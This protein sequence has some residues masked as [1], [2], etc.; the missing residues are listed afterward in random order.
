[1]PSQPDKATSLQPAGPAR[2]V[3]SRGPPSDFAV[4]GLGASAGGLDACRKFVEALPPK[5]GMAIIL[6]QHLDPTHQSMMVDLLAQHTT[7]PVEQAVEGMAVEPGHI[8]VIPPGNY[9]SVKSG[10]LHLMEPSA[11]HGARL[12]FNFLLHSLAEEYGPRAI[13]VVLSGTGADGSLGLASIHKAGGLVIVQDP[14][15]ALY[16]GMPR[17]AISTG[18][19][20]FVLPAKM[21]PDALL[22]FKRRTVTAH[23]STLSAAQDVIHARLTEI[24]A[25]LR[26]NTN[27]NFTHYKS[28]TLVRRIERRIALAGIDHADINRYFDLLRS[29]KNEQELLAKD[30]LINVTSFFR[31]PKVFEYLSAVTIPDLIRQHAPHTTLRVW[32]AGCSTGEEVYSLAIVFREVIAAASR[33]IKL[34]IFASDIDSDAVAIAREGFY[35]SSI[36]AVVSPE[37]LTRFFEKEDLG[38]R[39]TPEL[40]NMIIFA[41]QDILSD[42]PFSRLDMISCRNLLIYLRPE[43]QEKA[44]SA[45][46]FALRGD[47]VLLLGDSETVGSTSKRF[48]LISKVGQLYRPVGRASPRDVDFSAGSGVRVSARAPQE[49][50]APRQIALAALCQKMVIEA[51]APAVV[52][53]N[54]KYECL[55]CLGPTDKY[56]KIPPGHPIQDLLAMARDGIRAKLRTVIQQAIGENARVV[57]KGGRINL[58]DAVHRFSIAAQPLATDGE[59]LLMISFLDDPQP[60]AAESQPAEPED[61]SQVTVLEQELELTRAELQSAIR[62][63]EISSEAQKAVNEEALSVNEEFQSTNEELLTSKEELQ[64]LNEELTVLNSQLQETLARQRATSDDLRNVLYS[65]DIATIFLDTNLNIRFYTPAT[66]SLFSIIPSDVG[67]P[68]A[69]LNS[70]AGGAALLADAG[71]VLRTGSPIECEIETESRAV[72]IRRILPYRTEDNSI[73]GVVITFSDITERR[74]TAD[75]LEAAKRQ[76]DLATAAKSRFLAAASHDLRQP[77]QTLALLQELLEDA[78]KGDRAQNLISRVGETL[79]TMSSILDALLDLNQIDAGT[80]RTEIVRF[81]VSTLFE[82]LKEEFTYHA[83]AQGLTLRVVPCSCSIVSDPR[84][85]EQMLRNLLSNALKYTK[86]G[87]ILLGCRHRHGLLHIEVLDT[88]IGIPPEELDAIFEEYHQIDSAA[89]EH[90]RG[91][92]LGLSIVKRLADLLGHQVH[93]RSCVGK[94][95]AFSIDIM[96]PSSEPPA[97]LDDPSL[98]AGGVLPRPRPGTGS[99]LIVEDD[100][101]LRELLAQLLQKAGHRTIMAQDGK[102]ALEAVERGSIR[103]DLLLVDYNLPAGLNGLKVSEK[104]REMLHR[105]VPVI[106]LTGDVSA[107]ALR[108]MA[109]LDC[110][111]LSKPVKAKKL[112]LTVDRLL[113]PPEDVARVKPRSRPEGTTVFV[114]DDDRS[115]R[116]ALREEIEASGYTVEAFATG[117]EFLAAYQVQRQGCL[118]VDAYLPGMSGLDLLRRLSQ[119]GGQL[120]AIMITGHSDVSIAVQ[121]MKAGALDFVEKPVGKV[122]LL[123]CI[124]QALEYSRDAT[125]RRARREDAT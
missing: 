93:V 40:H 51:Y 39:V 72:F 65:T 14:D 83:E 15:E 9:L 31:D 79:A 120:P 36:E 122:E 41:V 92:G 7:M 107:G 47:G 43:A 110:V 27:H 91:L 42:P 13:C 82:R 119:T 26:A 123:A 112:L 33:R 74:R 103:P 111:Q 21:I 85:I 77:L 75:M 60:D 38:Y 117:E 101:Q 4:V 84:L 49:L 54:R 19:V 81:H 105:H 90:R 55:Y 98:E 63:L 8:Y 102:A 44:L 35:P 56:L 20:D 109:R 17:S 89:L 53:I 97:H 88:G 114:V 32:V 58:G 1:M 78:V 25:L 99:I 118:L 94:G 108:D 80:V 29:N 71:A 116:E 113:P 66:K 52:L 70:L 59:D 86:R 124:E 6:I 115:V 37:R 61:A 125:T 11:R 121:A 73:N 96:T 16:D 46:H 87:K 45:F 104:L 10:A 67:R 12:P 28:G 22:N 50:V 69:D 106:V 68:L 24:I 2:S 95:S 23:E 76:A 100:L 48:E 62:D 57:V 3:T 18:A 30:L 34:Q 5:N 64:S